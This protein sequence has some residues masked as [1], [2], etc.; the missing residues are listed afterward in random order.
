MSLPPTPQ[1]MLTPPDSH[2]SLS[3]TL[4][5]R[6]RLL[7][8]QKQSKYSLRRFLSKLHFADLADVFHHELTP[9]QT[10][11]CFS[12]LPPAQAALLLTSLEDRLALP[13]FKSLPLAK[14]SRVIRDMPVDEA[15]DLLQQLD[16]DERRPILG[17][18]PLDADTRQLHQLL[19]EAPDT[20]AGIMST[21]YMA[22]PVDKT[23]GEALQLVHH[24][25]EKDFIYYCYLLDRDDKLV[26]VVSLKTLVITPDE[27]PLN[28]VAC[29][30]MKT[31]YDSF[32]QELVAT[33]FRKYYNLLAMPVVDRHDR[34]LGIITLDD[35]LDVIDEESQD[36][37]FK[38]SGIVME[39][40]ATEQELIAGSVLPNVKAR[41]PW[42]AITLVGQLSVAA[43]IAFYEPTVSQAVKAFSFLPLLCGLAGNTG[44]QSDTITVRGIAL[45]HIRQGN[46]RQQLLREGRVGVLLGGIFSLVLGAASFALYHLWVLSALLMVYLLVAVTL[47]NC[48]G[49]FIAHT[50]KYRFNK[51]P[52][53]IGGPMI[54]TLSDVTLYLTYLLALMLLAKYVA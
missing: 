44:T 22:C 38:T 48:M 16:P 35:I 6:I 11:H 46:L 36:D 51:D 49:V 30:D 53:G 27:T 12:V 10:Q 33:V 19:I 2:T 18:L 15:V 31:V 4:A 21:D 39:D 8:K 1:E 40:T 50:V 17:G 41:L 5:Q 37:L 26:G 3:A 29:F 52:A 43:I 7:L 13:L 45:N 42:L 28:E 54:T 24:A 14:A 47:S 34:L 20:A 32:D 23:V 9:E 25:E